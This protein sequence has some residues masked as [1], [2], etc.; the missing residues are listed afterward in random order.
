MAPGGYAWWYLDALSD[1]GRYGIVLIAFIGSVFSPAYFRARRDA[2]AD[3]YAHCAIN[4]ALYGRGKERWA[5]SEY[6]RAGVNC[7]PGR[8]HIGASRL[9]WDGTAL[10]CELQERCAPLPKRIRGLVRLDSGALTSLA[11]PLTADGRHTWRPLAPQARVTVELEQPRLRWQGS[12]YLDSNEGSGALEQ[13]F[14][15]WTWLRARTAEGTAVIYDVSPRSG[16]RT[17]H[18]LHIA[19]S[20]AVENICAPPAV[21]LQRSRWGLR[22]H[23]AA[24]PGC[25]PRVL[26]RLEDAPFYCRSLVSTRLRGEAVTAVHESLSLTRFQSPWVRALLPFRMRRS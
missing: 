11:V 23:V 25:T 1:D 18:A 26:A 10:E 17:V 22:Q 20:G 4:V 14:S 6:G 15:Q 13:A 21:A 2:A 19:P 16:P 12:G 9:R 8:L 3:P 5:F 7:G 24:D